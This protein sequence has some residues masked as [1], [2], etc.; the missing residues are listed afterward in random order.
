MPQRYDQFVVEPLVVALAVIV[1][2]VFRHRVAHRFF[3]EHY[4]PVEARWFRKRNGL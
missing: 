1:R 4:E 3:A 2:E